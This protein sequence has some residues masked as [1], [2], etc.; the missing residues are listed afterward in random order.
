M[1]WISNV[2]LSNPSICPDISTTVSGNYIIN[3]YYTEYKSVSN[4]LDPRIDSNYNLI[5]GGVV[6]DYYISPSTVIGTK[7]GIVNT[8]SVQARIF[9]LM[10]CS[11]AGPLMRLL[12]AIV[13]WVKKQIETVQRILSKI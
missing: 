4:T 11:L 3:G 8:L 6:T 7:G 1:S 2:R 10:L 12:Q 9:L 13:P 5:L